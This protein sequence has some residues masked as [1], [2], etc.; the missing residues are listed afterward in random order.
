M[1]HPTDRIIQTTAFV[2]QVVEHWLERELASKQQITPHIYCSMWGVSRGG[3]GPR[4][5]D[6]YL[7]VEKCP[8]YLGFFV[9]LQNY[10][11]FKNYY[12]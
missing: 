12:S 8:F 9:F 1:H 7:K 4:C 3:G 2:T 11:V 5:L 6:P 10:L